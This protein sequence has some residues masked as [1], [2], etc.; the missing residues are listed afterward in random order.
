[1]LGSPYSMKLRA[2][3]R[4]RRLPHIW[5]VLFPAMS[6]RRFSVRPL[7][8]PILCF[9][10]GSEHVDSTP[11]CEE[12]ERSFPGSR[13]VYPDDPAARFASLLIEDF[14]DEWLTKAMFHYRWNYPED[15]A[16]CS[17]WLASDIYPQ[18]D[19]RRIDEAART[20]AERQV[21]RL[22]IVGCDVANTAAIESGLLDLLEILSR[23]LERY[24]YLFGTRPSIAD[25]SIYGQ[26]SQLVTDPVPA[27][28]IREK[29]QA[30]FDWVR[31]I[32]DASGVVGEWLP[33][34]TQSDTVRDL[35][36]LIGRDYLPFL[37]ANDE[38]L[39]EDSSTVSVSLRGRP[40]QQRPFRYQQ[41]CLQ[42][43]RSLYA[44]RDRTDTRPA[45]IF[46]AW[47]RAAGLSLLGASS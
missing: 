12:L 42:R 46:A 5:T 31:R 17:R 30:V 26:L 4:Y 8:L 36:A 39:R 15:V 47:E 40:F 16:Y 23:H 3:M 33:E 38:A 18:A 9:P 25:F 14:A 1:M 7:L 11:I 19:P 6:E 43:L 10:D 27:R 44:S 2:V 13:S 45:S 41:K 32:D 24:P 28:V 29:A 21:S 34:A 20:L 22:Q 37:L 35:L